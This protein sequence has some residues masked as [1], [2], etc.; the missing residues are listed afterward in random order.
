MPTGRDLLL[1]EVQNDH[2]LAL[3]RCDITAYYLSLQYHNNK[4]EAV[5]CLHAI[6]LRVRMF[7]IFPNGLCPSAIVSSRC[8]S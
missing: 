7:G 2:I 5:E 4:N 8:R 3:W 6:A 1:L